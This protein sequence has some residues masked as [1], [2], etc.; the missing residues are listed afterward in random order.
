MCWFNVS[1]YFIAKYTI[2]AVTKVTFSELA[3]AGRPATVGGGPSIVVGGLPGTSYK[4]CNIF[5]MDFFISNYY[6]Y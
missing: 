2:R 1:I 6:K 3:T 4:K 5:N